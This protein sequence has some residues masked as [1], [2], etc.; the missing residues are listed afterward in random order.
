MKVVLSPE[1]EELVNG[2]VR[3]GLYPT[4]E[5]VVEDALHLLREKDQTEAR[6]EELLQEAED[7]GPGTAMTEEDWEDIRRQVRERSA[8]RRS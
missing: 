1:L 6:M 7:S 5:A 8:E 4:P 2:K 3:L